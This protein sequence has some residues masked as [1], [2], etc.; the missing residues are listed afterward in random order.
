MGE[1]GRRLAEEKYGW[2]KVAERVEGVYEELVR[3]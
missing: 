3:P 2:R 1:A